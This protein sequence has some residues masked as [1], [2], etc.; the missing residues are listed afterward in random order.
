MTLRRL[1]N[2]SSPIGTVLDAVDDEGGILLEHEG[3]RTYALMPLNDDLLDYLLEH[4]PKLIK[5]SA[6]IRRR[7]KYGAF[8]THEQVKRMLKD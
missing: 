8:H 5:K 1:N 4:N 7:M 6:R 2:P 3:R